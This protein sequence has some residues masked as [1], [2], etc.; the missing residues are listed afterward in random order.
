MP[1]VY[2][3]AEQATKRILFSST[4]TAT[5][6]YTKIGSFDHPDA[7]Y[8]DSYVIFHGIR[9]LMYFRDGA[10]ITKTAFFP[11]SLTN[12]NEWK[13]I[14]ADPSVVPVV[15]LSFDVHE[16][17]ADTETTGAALELGDELATYTG[18]R[19]LRVVPRPTGSVGE[20]TV[21]VTGDEAEHF[22]AELDA[23]KGFGVIAYSRDEDTPLAAKVTLT[24]R[25]GSGQF[26]TTMIT[27]DL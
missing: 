10:D 21:T 22:H 16:Y 27:A 7:T 3:K 17:A 25:Q 18:T 13:I 12:F 26:Y 15:T 5:A 1:K 8:P 23:S 2:V 9:G 4:D 20:I 19:Y 6:G 24:I 14:N 11:K